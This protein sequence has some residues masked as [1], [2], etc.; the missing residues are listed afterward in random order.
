[1]VASCSSSTASSAMTF[2]LAPAGATCAAGSQPDAKRSTPRVRAIDDLLGGHWPWPKHGVARSHVPAWRRVGYARPAGIGTVRLR[3]IATAC[4]RCLPSPLSALAPGAARRSFRFAPLLRHGSGDIGRRRAWTRRRSGSGSIGASLAAALTGLR[5]PADRRGVHG[6][7]H[8]DRR[9][10]PAGG[11]TT[12]SRATWSCHPTI[13]HSASP[14]CGRA[15]SCGS[16]WSEPAAGARLR[17]Q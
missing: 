5:P 4:A 10:P 14:N 11:G 17:G 8:R 1:M 15:A 2:H 6:G 3:G 12:G 9:H 16:G 13:V 7:W